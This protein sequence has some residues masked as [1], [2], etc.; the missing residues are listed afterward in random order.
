MM[1]WGTALVCGTVIVAVLFALLFGGYFA[2][3]HVAILESFFIV[4]D[5]TE[6][7]QANEG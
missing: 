5:T 3:Q 7:I 1:G 6:I 4:L 2:F